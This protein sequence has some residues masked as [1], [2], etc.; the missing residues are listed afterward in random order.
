M[1]SSFFFFAKILDN[2][3]IHYDDVCFNKMNEWAFQD[4]D[5]SIKSNYT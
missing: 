3:K 1:S 2:I 5:V 4:K